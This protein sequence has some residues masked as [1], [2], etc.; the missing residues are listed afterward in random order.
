MLQNKKYIKFASENTVEVMALSR[1]QEGIEKEDRKA[2]TYKAKDGTVYLVEFPNLTVADIK[3]MRSTKAGTYNKTGKIPYTAIV[4]PHT[5]EEMENLKGGYSGKTLMEIVKVHKK[6]LSKEHGKSISRKALK[7]VRKQQRQIEEELEKESYS[8]ALSATAKLE[9]SVAKAPPALVEMVGKTKAG[10]V[11][12]CSKKLDSLEALIGRGAKGEA[13][14]ELG[15]LTR[16]LKGTSLEER[17]K[18]LLAQAK[19]E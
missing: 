1:L 12:A 9:K 14:K 16:A 2:A 11:A 8:K 15:S 5:L 19:A 17:A 4:D 6:T 13:A 18:E 7:K 10:V 3:K